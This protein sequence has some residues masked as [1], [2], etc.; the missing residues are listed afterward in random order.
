MSQEFNKK[1]K[2]FSNILS[3]VGTMFTKRYLKNRSVK[4]AS[5]GDFVNRVQICVPTFF[6]IIV[7]SLLFILATYYKISLALEIKNI[8]IDQDSKSYISYQIKLLNAFLG[9]IG[10]NLMFSLTIMI[11]YLN[12]S[13]G[14]SIKYFTIFY[15]VVF[16]FQILIIS[17]IAF[18]LDFFGLLTDISSIKLWSDFLVEGWIWIVVIGIAVFTFTLYGKIFSHINGLNREWLKISMLK[19]TGSREN[20]FIFKFWIHPNENRARKLMIISGS[21]S[22]VMASALHLISVFM[23]VNI[24]EMKY[25]LLFLGIIV[26]F[27]SFIIPYN[28]FSIYYFGA[29]LLVFTGLV[30]YS[31]VIIQKKSFLNG[32]QYLYVYFFNIIIWITCLFSNINIWIAVLNKV[33]IYAV[34]VK[35]FESD[36]DFK[37]GVKNLTSPKL[38]NSV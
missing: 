23:K 29:I 33:K 37:E 18:V 21:M 25:F 14:K 7:C 6:T 32:M 30:I 27:A 11:F 24:N 13:L 15:N 8:N 22:M 16:V 35:P 12:V 2:N 36:E 17:N 28:N 19:K 26:I 34:V 31:L 10:F 1:Y 4:I 9:V 5:E 20:A 3:P 38:E